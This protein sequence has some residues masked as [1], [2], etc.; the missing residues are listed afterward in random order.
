M[1]PSQSPSR[2]RAMLRQGGANPQNSAFPL[3][4][5]G[6]C[7]EYEHKQQRKKL[8]LS[9]SVPLS[10]PQ[11]STGVLGFFLLPTLAPRPWSG[12]GAVQLKNKLCWDAVMAELIHQLGG[13]TR[14]NLGGRIADESFSNQED[15]GNFSCLSTSLISLPIQELGWGGCHE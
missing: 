14:S 6:S 5:H 8:P 15:L 3:S 13:P 7:P 10:P 12:M 9:P 11:S 1:C 2:F 4:S